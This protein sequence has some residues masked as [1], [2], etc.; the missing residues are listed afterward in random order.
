MTR[1]CFGCIP[2]RHAARV[3]MGSDASI[4]LAEGQT[5]RIGD[6]S[7]TNGT[8]IEMADYANCDSKS[9]DAD[10]RLPLALA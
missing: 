2:R 8:F 7:V 3:A 6:L 5:G 10:G 1:A 9:Y 4:V